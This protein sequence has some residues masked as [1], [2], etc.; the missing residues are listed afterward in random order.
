MFVDSERARVLRQA[1]R[2]SHESPIPRSRT[3]ARV[4]LHLGRRSLE[5]RPAEQERQ[6]WDISQRRLPFSRM[7]RQGRW[8]TGNH[9]QCRRNASHGTHAREARS[10]RPY[11]VFVEAF[12]RLGCWTKAV[13]YVC[14]S[15]VPNERRVTYLHRRT[16]LPGRWRSGGGGSCTRRRLSLGSSL[17]SLGDLEGEWFGQA[18]FPLSLLLFLQPRLQLFNGNTFSVRC[19]RSM[20][21][22][23]A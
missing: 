12:R 22:C 20:L 4:D 14:A 6:S 23:R 17:F 16:I 21:L 8:H 9:D 10:A 18:F 11:E 7:Q 5:T 15:S 2:A 3:R 13:R 19:Q 1:L